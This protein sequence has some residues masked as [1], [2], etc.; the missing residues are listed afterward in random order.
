MPDRIV[1]YI[2]QSSMVFY[3]LDEKWTVSGFNCVAG[4]DVKLTVS[5]CDGAGNIHEKILDSAAIA[6]YE[7]FSLLAA[8]EL[9]GVVYQDTGI[10][11]LD[12]ALEILTEIQ[13]P[14]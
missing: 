3:Y 2:K 7:Q 14:H 11:E 12:K 13:K 1:H 8:M 10:I 9:I 5:R 6:K 4:G